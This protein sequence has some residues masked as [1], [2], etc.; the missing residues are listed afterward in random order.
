MGRFLRQTWMP[1]L[2][3]VAVSATI[4]A[5]L[6]FGYWITAIGLCGL[7]ATPPLWWTLVARSARPGMGRGAA[8][9]AL[10]GLA[11]YAFPLLLGVI[12]FYTRRD[13]GLGA[14]GD[15]LFFGIMIGGAVAAAAVNAAL[16]ALLIRVGQRKE[17]PNV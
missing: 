11:S 17:A 1:T 7:V 13:F 6:L 15:V 3:F 9:G 8:A 12:S 4:A 10:S 14:M 5:V 16:G 2:G